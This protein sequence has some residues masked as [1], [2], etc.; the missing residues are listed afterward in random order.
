MFRM[1]CTIFSFSGLL[2]EWLCSAT[3]KLPA[4]S[5]GSS[6]MVVLFLATS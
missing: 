1:V 2:P 4:S 3:H 6:T 5:G